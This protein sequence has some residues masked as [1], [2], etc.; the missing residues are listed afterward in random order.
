MSEEVI[1]DEDAG[2][3]IKLRGRALSIVL[4]ERARLEKL[5]RKV[6]SVSEVV[7][8]MVIECKEKR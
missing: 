8:T 2:V 5:A 1:S 7:S 4:S 6:Y 3:S